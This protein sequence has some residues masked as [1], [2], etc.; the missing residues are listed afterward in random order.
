MRSV[1]FVLVVVM[2]F[3]SP[4]FGGVPVF[5]YG[6]ESSEKSQPLPEMTEAIYE[7]MK[8]GSA[9][10]VSGGATTKACI[11]CLIGISLARAF[12]ND[13]CKGFGWIG[14]AP[15]VGYSC[16]YGGPSPWGHG[17]VRS[18]EYPVFGACFE[19]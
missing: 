9:P 18:V 10:P 4:F 13:S 14:A 5:A 16:L 2:A 8:N 15:L 7:S 17:R 12:E 1:P 11:P 19:C 6:G 3:T